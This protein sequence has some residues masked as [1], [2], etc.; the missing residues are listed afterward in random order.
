MFVGH[1]FWYECYVY[2]FES[3]NGDEGSTG[4]IVGVI[5]LSF[6]MYLLSKACV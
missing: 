4:C 3:L 2:A 1:V 5:V 6:C